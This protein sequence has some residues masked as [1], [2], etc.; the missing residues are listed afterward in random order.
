MHGLSSPPAE[1][2]TPSSASHIAARS[3]LPRIEQH[4]SFA[5]IVTK[6]SPWFIQTIVL[7][8]SFEDLQKKSIGQK[9]DPMVEYLSDQVHHTALVAALIAL[10]SHFASLD[11][12]DEGVNEARGYACEIVAYRFLS[13]LTEWETIDYLLYEVAT[14]YSKGEGEN[15]SNGDSRK[16]Q[17]PSKQTDTDEETPLLDE[18]S[19]NNGKPKS[20]LTRSTS[21][22]GQTQ[23]QAA[24]PNMQKDD[25]MA[26]F[27]GMN[28]LEI[29]SVVN[30]KKFLSQRVVQRI[31][32]G[33]WNGDIVFWESMSMYSERKPHIYNSR[34]ADPCTRLRVPKYQK[35]FD[36]LFFITFLILYYAVLVDRSPSHITTVEVFLLIWIAGFAYNEF[37]DIRDTG[38]WFYA[39]DFWSLWDLAI[40]VIGVLYLILRAVGLSRSMEN[41]NS[42]SLDVLSLEALFLVPRIFSLLSLHPYYGT[43]IPCLKQMTKDFVKFLSLVIILYL[44]FFTTFALLARDSFTL[45]EVSWL[46]IKVFFGSSYMGFDEMNKISPVLG[47]PLMIIFVC[48]T[49]MLLITSLISILSNSLS[50]PPPAKRSMQGRMQRPSLG[51]QIKQFLA[52]GMVA[53]RQPNRYSVFVLEASTSRR[54]TL[55]WP[56]MN[57]LSIFLRPLRLFMTPEQF[58][59]ARIVLLKTTHY[60][61]VA[62]IALVEKTQQHVAAGSAASSR[63]RSFRPA[64]AS[65]RPDSSNRPSM[66]LQQS[67]PQRSLALRNE[68]TLDGGDQPSASK[69]QQRSNSHQHPHANNEDHQ[70]VADQV[71]DVHE[72]I[73][74]LSAQIEGLTAALTQ[75]QG[76]VEKHDGET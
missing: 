65:K 72:Q 6:L 67:G 52:F 42:A 40:I 24:M 2:Q 53:K 43:L 59:G 21:R 49:N 9:L 63:Y 75:Q 1:Q 36:A 17:K 51:G 14:D 69:S 5:S 25:P 60:P 12:N 48:M 74:K 20:K 76:R 15:D 28:A 23:E 58:R 64:A 50:Q 31:V 62:L 22:F 71:A 19:S 57:L 38:T 55:F 33:I 39:A 11:P 46:L 61:F 41:L 10:K 37:S 56:P 66:R 45:S 7:A 35:A 13:Y 54:L 26:A 47:P 68:T 32:T 73:R 18:E 3:E 34:T 44:G 30:A 70:A 16:T 8:R 29:A 27:H 4:D